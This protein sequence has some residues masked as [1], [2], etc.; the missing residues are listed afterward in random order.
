MLRL[1]FLAT[2]NLRPRALVTCIQPT[3]GGIGYAAAIEDFRKGEE[4]EEDYPRWRA[5]L[6]SIAYAADEHLVRCAHRIVSMLTKSDLR[7]LG[8]ARSV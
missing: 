7:Y 2:S 4:D 8:T 6:L 5:N 1:D 3:I